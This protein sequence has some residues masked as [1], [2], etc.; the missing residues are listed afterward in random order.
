MKTKIL[1][2][3]K[4][5][6]GYV[7][8]QELCERLGVSRTAVWKIIR[9][10]EEEGYEIEAVRNRGYRL[11]GSADILNEAEIRAVLTSRWLGQNVKF[12]EETDSTNN[13]IRRMA[14]QGAPEG[15]LAVAEIQTAGKGRRGRS[16]S[17][18]KGSGIWHSFLLRPD[19]APEHASMLTLL[20]AMAVQKA[21]C[22]VTGLDGLIK[23]PND[24]V[25]NG[26]KICG[27]LTEMSTEED[28][29]RYVVVGI[30]IN[31]NTP[32]FPEEIRA[33]ATSLALEL[34]HPVRRALLINGIMCAFE[35]YYDIYRQTLD[36]S[37]LKEIYNQRLVN[38]E[39]EV[40]VLAPRGDYTGVSHGINDEGE[41]IVELADGTIREVNSGEVSVRGIYGYV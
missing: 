30:G 34:G 31:A 24:I 6:D 21:V 39:R 28:T 19:F 23:W 3:L 25:V 26:K 20:A 36:M 8:G 1:K 37:R 41:L 38:V 22:D 18:P 4:E 14:E 32:D 13:V 12:L 17:S 15:T 29:I 7:S 27:I 33:T 40:K 5:T 35:E 11:T 10:L 16:W 2:Y 9:Q